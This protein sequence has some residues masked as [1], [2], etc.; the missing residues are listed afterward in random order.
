[1]PLSR[2]SKAARVAGRGGHRASQSPH[3]RFAR[4]MTVLVMLASFVPAAAGQASAQVVTTADPAAPRAAKP[5]AAAA[6]VVPVPVSMRTVPGASFSLS[7]DTRIVVAGRSRHTVEVAEDLA[8]ILRRSTGYRLPVTQHGRASHAISLST[9]DAGQLGREG[10]RLDVTSSRASL[11]ART[12]EGL[13]RG[14]QTLLQLLPARAEAPTVQPGPWVVPGVR[15]EDRPRFAWRGAMLDVSR[16]FFTPAQVKRYIDLAAR[17]KV[18]MLH[19]HLSDDQGWRIAIDSWP[20]LATYGGSTAVGGGPGGYYTKRDYSGIVRYAAARYMTVVPEIDSPG[21]TNAALASYAELNC[22]GKAPP[23][24]TG[25]DVGF[26]SLCTGKEIT[27]RFLDDVVREIAALTPGPYLHIGGDEAHS[28]KPEDYVSFIERVQKIVH[29]HGKRMMGWQDVAAAKIAPSS[30]AQFWQPASGSEEAT[31]DA[32]DAVR[33]GAKLVMSPA[34]RTYLDMKYNPSTP[35]GQDWAGLIE[36]RDSY[37][38][39]PGTLID[40]VTEKSVLGVEAP[41]WTET[42][43]TNAHIDYMAFPR[44]ASIAEIGWSPQGSRS[45]DDFRLRLAAQ[46]PRWTVKSVDFY[47]SP[48]IPWP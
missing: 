8:A 11:R 25:T 44:L 47:R 14:V 18:N 38:W 31:Q 40:G 4:L 9:T 1:M 10:Y 16:H 34:N 13:F 29:A 39:N 15:I 23:L 28:T 6:R 35:L 22:D 2:A 32:R 26:S 42:I 20:R 24:Y 7:R 5:A 3:G 19:L 21:H 46:G 36:V 41:L 17:Y 37:E 43:V 12:A 27:Y 45:W 48:Q 30:M 33:Q